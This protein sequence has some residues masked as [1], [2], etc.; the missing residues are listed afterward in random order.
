M[1]DDD[2]RVIYEA[3]AFFREGEAKKVLEVWKA[4]GRREALGM[5]SV[6]VYDSADEWQSDR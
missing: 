3:G 6:A 5:N 1:L 2:G 4:E